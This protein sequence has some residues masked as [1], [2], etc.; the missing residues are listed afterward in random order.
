MLN[1]IRKRIIVNFFKK[2]VK[3][4]DKTNTIYTL[5]YFLIFNSDELIKILTKIQ[6][7]VRV[8]SFKNTTILFFYNTYNYT[9]NLLFNKTSFYESLYTI[10]QKKLKKYFKNISII[11]LQIIVFDI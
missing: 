2:F 4:I 11:I 8:F 7:Y 3:I 6:K 10:F 1:I 9:I 5:I